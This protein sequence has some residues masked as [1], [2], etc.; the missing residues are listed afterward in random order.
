M[1]QLILEAVKPIAEATVNNSND[2]LEIL[3]KVNEFYDSS[4]NKLL[5]VLSGAFAVLAIAVPFV[6]QYIQNKTIKASEKELENKIIDEIKKAKKSITQDLITAF[7]AKTKEY[8]IKLRKLNDELSGMVMDINGINHLGKTEFFEAFQSF[9]YS[10]DYYLNAGVNYNT[11]LCLENLTT[12]LKELE[13]EDIEELR[14]RK[15]YDLELC[16]NKIAKDAD[17]ETIELILSLR[18]KLKKPNPLN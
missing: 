14:E 4:W 15:F 10:L 11:K 8:D 16:L 6:I 9:V 7:D 1:I 5:Y 3:S 12:C 18:E 2:T 17:T 13:Q